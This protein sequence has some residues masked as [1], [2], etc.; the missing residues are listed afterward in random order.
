MMNKCFL[1]LWLMPLMMIGQTNTITA[2]PYS[3]YGIG[4]NTKSN[5]GRNSALG[6]GGYAFQTIDQINNHN[7]A[8]FAAIPDNNFLYDFGLT[9]QLSSVSSKGNEEKRLAGNISN[10]AI[11]ATTGARSGFG[12]TLEPYSDVGYALIGVESNIEGSY[13]TF[14]SN[15]FGSG[16]LNDLKLNYGYIL[17]DRLR[18]G[19]GLSYIFGTIKETQRIQ[20]QYNSLEVEDK[21]KYSGLRMDVGLQGTISDHLKFGFTAR[22]PTSLKV[23]HDRRI[24]KMVSLIPK[25]QVVENTTGEHLPNFDLPLEL[26]GGIVYMPSSSWTI[27]LDYSR[28]FWNATDQNDNIGTFID[29]EIF[30]VGIEYAVDNQSIN[31]WKRIK[32]RIGGNHDSGYLEVYD[33][34]IN[35]YSIS[36]GI[37]IPLSRSSKS[38]INISYGRSEYG[39]SQGVLVEETFNTFNVNISLVDI[40]FLKRKVN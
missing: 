34:V 31:Y 36:G 15:I 7:P 6:G 20:S 33:Y 23:T 37:G 22:L 5:I 35:G 38:S 17:K 27:N 12:L 2:S 10:L 26:G 40:W 29:Q 9:A 39:A 13:D 32:F 30:G 16:G 19:V 28:N 3:L 21:N 4:V 1:L 24:S 18:V 8:S 14:I 11:A 25:P